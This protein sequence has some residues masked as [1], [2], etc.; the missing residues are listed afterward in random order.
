[1]LK[2]VSV[3][4]LTL[5]I[6]SAYCPS[7]FAAN[8]DKKTP[9]QK[10]EIWLKAP[11]K[12]KWHSKKLIWEKWWRLLDSL[13]LEKAEKMWPAAVK[14]QKASRMADVAHLLAQKNEN[15]QSAKA[16]YQDKL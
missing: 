9:E 6:V 11:A 16:Y 12:Q 14:T 2:R 13:P 10:L 3:I 4:I 15:Y 7:L 8:N 5:L 1:M